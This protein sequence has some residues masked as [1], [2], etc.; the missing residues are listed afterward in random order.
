MMKNTLICFCL[1]ALMLPLVSNGQF[2]TLGNRSVKL[3]RFERDSVMQLCQ[4]KDPEIPPINIAHLIK[5]TAVSLP[6]RRMMV[7]SPRGLRK[8]PVYGKTAIHNGID[9]RAHY[10]SVFSIM[11]GIVVAIGHD[12]SSGLWIQVLHSGR[13]RSTYAHLSR[14]MVQKGQMVKS[15]ESIG[16]SGN[17]GASTAPH[18]HFSMKRRAHY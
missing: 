18:L 5:P 13:L 2:H 9:L 15:G 1:Q 11:E 17:S 3:N 4:T 10:D 14:I 8:H 7:T 16:I 6:L 12:H